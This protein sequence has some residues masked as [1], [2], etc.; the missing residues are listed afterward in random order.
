MI[1][2]PDFRPRRLSAAYDILRLPRLARPWRAVL[3]VLLG[4]FLLPYLLTLIYTVVNPISTVMLWARGHRR[5]GGAPIRPVVAYRAGA[6][7]GR[8]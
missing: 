6:A 5:A 4:L 3:Y 8:W 2:R 1:Y 7:A